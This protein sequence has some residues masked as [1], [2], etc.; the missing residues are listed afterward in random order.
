M[1]IRYNRQYK[2]VVDIEGP[3]GPNTNEDQTNLNFLNNNDVYLGGG[4]GAGG[5]GST[6]VETPVY[7]DPPY[8]IN[9]PIDIIQPTPDNPAPNDPTDPRVSFQ[10]SHD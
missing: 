1:S 7:V 6:P 8:T 2:M 3:V 4:G 10:T 5:G 9:P